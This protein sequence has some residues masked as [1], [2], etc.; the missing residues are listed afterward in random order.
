[1]FLLHTHSSYTDDRQKFRSDVNVG[2][3]GN[4][5]SWDQDYIYEDSL[6][7]ET[8]QKISL[9]LEDLVEWERR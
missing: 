8:E 3:K 2:H 1:M 6:I 4:K 9:G 5:V 7:E